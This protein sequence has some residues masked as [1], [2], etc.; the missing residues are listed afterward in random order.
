[1]SKRKDD[2]EGS[3]PP[4]AKKRATKKSSD[5]NSSS[6]SSSVVVLPCVPDGFQASRAR[7][8]TTN[9]DLPSGGE[10]VIY[11]MSRD[12]RVEDNHAMLYARGCAAAHNV[13]LKVM[14]NLVP[15]FLEATLRQ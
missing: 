3:S 2:D 8:L 10:C 4:A 7:L 1:M 11:W 12:Q 5:T 15:T 13:P 9:R 14:F 6:S